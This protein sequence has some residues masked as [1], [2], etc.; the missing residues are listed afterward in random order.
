M[1]SRHRLPLALLAILTAAPL[2]RAEVPLG[3]VAGSR[4]GFEGMLQADTYWFDNDLA[5]LGG[6]STSGMR[7]AEL[8]LKGKGPG[9]FDWVV[10]YDAKSEKWLDVNLGWKSA[11]G[12]Q[13]QLGQ[14]KQPL[15]LEELT[16]SKHNDFIAKAAVTSTWALSRRLGAGYAVSGKSWSLRAAAFTR[17]L[18][19]DNAMGDGVALRGAWTAI[20]GKDHTLHLGIAHARYD[21][22]LAG[23]PDAQRWRARPQADMAVVRLVDTGILVGADDVQTTGLEAMWLQGP[24]KLQA[25]AM[26]SI[27]RRHGAAAFTGE[28]GYASALWNLTGGAFGYKAGVPTTPSPAAPTRG[29]LQLGLRYDSL[30]LD[31]GHVVTSPVTTV[32]GVLGGRMQAW[33]VGANYYWRSNLKLALNYV[34]ASSRKYNVGLQSHRHDDPDAVELRAQLHW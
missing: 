26:R 33:T 23:T 14:F 15:G 25:E 11:S 6:D 13:L 20:H 3:T 18:T 12:H 28:G 29:M 4:I 5:D 22:E 9:S 16:S 21:A 31:D 24:I 19:R 32:A 1:T 17:E 2:A 27:T 8:V 34:S 7:R 10:G 30:D